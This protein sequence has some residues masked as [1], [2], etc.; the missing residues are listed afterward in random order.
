MIVIETFW[1][2]L[3]MTTK[4][5]PSPF[6]FFIVYRYTCI[7]VPFKISENGRTKMAHLDLV[8]NVHVYFRV[9]V[10]VQIHVHAYVHVA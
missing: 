10:P 7:V 6:V 3:P 4:I 2:F 5:Q 8:G 1:F 9:H